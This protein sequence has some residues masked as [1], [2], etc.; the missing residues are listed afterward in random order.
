M[1]V[2]VIMRVAILLA[3][4]FFLAAPG[5]QATQVIFAED[6]ESGLDAWTAD[7]PW[8]IEADTD[9][10]GSLIAPF[11][12]G[13]NGAYYGSPTCTFSLYTGRSDLIM[14]DSIHI[15]A[16]PVTTLRFVGYEDAECGSCG[17]DWRRVAIYS[18]TLGTEDVVWEDGSLQTWSEQVVD[19]TDYAGQDIRIGF[20]FDPVDHFLNEHFGWMIDDVRVEVTEAPEV[21]CQTA[22]NTVGPG[23]R[24]GWSGYTSVAVDDFR[25]HGSGA[26]PHQIGMF[27]YGPTAVSLP[28][29]NGTR[30][31]GAGATGTVRLNPPAQFDVAGLIWRQVDFTAAPAAS[32]FGMIAGG[33]EWFFQLWYRDDVGAGHNLSDALRVPFSL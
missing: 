23:A 8:H 11:P 14:V 32:G 17:W 26:P 10:C 25:L 4:S 24:I 1:I 2:A 7:G 16:G 22:P 21:Y 27:Y 12:T 33:S 29:G 5:A 3:A 31:V 19:L 15:P 28:F 13:S 9:P 20:W 6:F 18:D 30:C